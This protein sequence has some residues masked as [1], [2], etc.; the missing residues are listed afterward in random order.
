MLDWQTILYMISL[1]AS[2]VAGILLGLRLRKRKKID[3]SRASLV[4]IIVL[5]FALGFNIGSNSELLESLPKV[6]L[7]AVV[8]A[9]LAM[10]FSLL[11]IKVIRRSVSL[12]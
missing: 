10:S 2:L 1:T 12:K 4:V 11:F 9:L 5:I 3:L 6:G 8:I 7:N